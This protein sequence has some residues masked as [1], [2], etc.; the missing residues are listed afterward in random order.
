MLQWWCGC[1]VGEDD[2]GGDGI[3][4]SVC[5]WDP[6]ERKVWRSETNLEGRES[7]Y[8]ASGY[9]SNFMVFHFKRLVYPLIIEFFHSTFGLFFLALICS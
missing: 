3:G 2:G 9:F 7:W 1:R 5:D 4:G 8:C 6:Q